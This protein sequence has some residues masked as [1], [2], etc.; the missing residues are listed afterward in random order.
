MTNKAPHQNEDTFHRA[1]SRLIDAFA[2]LEAKLVSLLERA[3]RPIKGDTVASKLKTI[4][5]SATPASIER[6]VPELDRLGVLIPVRADIVHGTMVLIDIDGERFANFRNARESVN[7]AQR[8]TQISYRNLKA[9]TEE[10][11]QITSA[12]DQLKFNPPS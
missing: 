3:G 9:F 2:K 6:V 10:L 8:A 5:D 7:R 11:D 1:R 12:L 4:R